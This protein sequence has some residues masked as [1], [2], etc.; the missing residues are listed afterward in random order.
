[1]CDFRACS[2]V[3]VCVNTGGEPGQTRSC[4]I[5]SSSRVKQQSGPSWDCQSERE[6]EGLVESGR[7][8]DRVEEGER[9]SMKKHDLFEHVAHED[10]EEKQIYTG[11]GEMCVNTGSWRK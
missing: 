3:C 11:F 8:W 6:G 9:E 2:S 10:R 1:M 5:W 7:E 4:H